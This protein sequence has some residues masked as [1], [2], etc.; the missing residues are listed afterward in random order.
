M[1]EMTPAAAPMEPTPERHTPDWRGAWEELYATL[2]PSATNGLAAAYG[3][4]DDP[5]ADLLDVIAERHHIPP[6][7]PA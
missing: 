4:S 1:S 7:D 2:S 3:L 6:G 5:E